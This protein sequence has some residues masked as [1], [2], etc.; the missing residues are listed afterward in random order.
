MADEQKS[1]EGGKKPPR[2][3]KAQSPG[4]LYELEHRLTQKRITVSAGEYQKMREVYSY[5]GDKMP[6]KVVGRKE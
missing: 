3:L 5:L 4:S 2:S 1:A 6:Y